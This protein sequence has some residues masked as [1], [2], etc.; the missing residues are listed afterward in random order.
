M[1]EGG[2]NYVWPAYAVTG[3]ALLVLTIVVLVRAAHW[4]KRAKALD[5]AK[6]RA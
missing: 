2:W 1:I 4:A 3:A 6:E 5:A